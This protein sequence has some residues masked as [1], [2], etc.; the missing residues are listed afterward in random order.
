M[1]KPIQPTSTWRFEETA[2]NNRLDSRGGPRWVDAS[3]GSPTPSSTTAKFG[4]RSAGASWLQG[5]LR[6]ED[7]ASVFPQGSFS[8]AVWL[9]FQSVG[10]QQAYI[11]CKR[12]SAGGGGTARYWQID[13]LD[14]VNAPERFTFYLRNAANDNDAYVE[15]AHVP[16][17]STWILLC[18]KY[19]AAEQL[20][21]LSVN[22]APFTTAA[23]TGGLRAGPASIVTSLGKTG[24]ESVAN[25]TARGGILYDNLYYWDGYALNDQHAAYLYNNGFGQDDPF[26]G[27][28][29]DG[30]LRNGGE[31]RIL[32]SPFIGLY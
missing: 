14:T 12:H 15:V 5:Y 8:F 23:A 7:V 1:P 19:D 20:V 9:N 28:D 11:V 10:H 3:A 22:G 16:T 30:S 21:G 13:H 25:N 29:V 31:S 27:G 26:V 24:D 17:L 2:G 4:S 32:T 18:I 6:M